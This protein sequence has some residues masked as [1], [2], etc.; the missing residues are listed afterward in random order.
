MSLAYFF[1]EQ[2]YYIRHLVFCIV[3]PIIAIFLFVLYLRVVPQSVFPKNKSLETKVF[4]LIFK[5]FCLCRVISFISYIVFYQTNINLIFKYFADYKNNVPILE[6]VFM[7]HQYSKPYILAVV[8]IAPICEEIIYRR[9]IYDSIK[10]Q[11]H[12][13]VVAAIISSICFAVPHF[14]FNENIIYNYRLI[15]STFLHGLVLSYCYEKGNRILP[16]MIIHFL[17]NFLAMIE[18]NL[19]DT[20]NILLQL[21]LFLISLA[22]IIYV[23][24]RYLLTLYKKHVVSQEATH[25][26]EM[27][28]HISHA[29]SSNNRLQDL[30][31]K[32]ILGLVFFSCLFESLIVMQTI[33]MIFRLSVDY[34]IV[35]YASIQLAF[36]V[37]AVLYVRDCH[38][39]LSDV[40][41]KKSVN[42]NWSLIVK[43]LC[44]TFV[45]CFVFFYLPNVSRFG[46]VISFFKNN[47]AVLDLS[48]FNVTDSSP[49]AFIIFI[50]I[51]P[52][53]EQMIFKFGVYG[54][55]KSKSR[56]IPIAMFVSFVVFGLLYTLRL[57]FT[58][59]EL[60][61][62]FCINLFLLY[63]Y[64]KS[65]SILT[66]VVL[67][68]FI[69]VILFLNR[70]LFF[71]YSAPVFSALASVS[72][73]V[74]GF[75]LIDFLRR[76]KLDT[77][78]GVDEVVA[79]DVGMTCEKK[80]E[81]AIEGSVGETC[82]LD[83]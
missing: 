78:H 42:L 25:L 74:L 66:C 45:L 35:W 48:I 9:V 21:F 70:Y 69:T 40:L 32:G 2:T 26:V 53:I 29:S 39:S 76:R 83:E 50:F 63:A 54:F 68:V 5:C 56:I 72:V 27:S 71:V 65:E 34:K 44:A 55:V 57:G 20:Y 13:F 16:C 67:Q 52:I 14:N 77:E 80:A 62:I 82:K 59:T 58:L 19:H 12:S 24:V 22:V 36:F 75:T 79:L 73:V 8:I 7:L 3:L 1:I 18:N 30:K 31:T 11:S 41:V 23:F 6:P 64:K 60:T 46:S 33:I 47:N 81:R 43:F 37:V 4:L 10:R 28:S 17:W 38:V 15:A 51:A 61:V 49:I